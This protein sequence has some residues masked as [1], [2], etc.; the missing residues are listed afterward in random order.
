RAHRRLPERRPPPRLHVGPSRPG[1]RT[2]CVRRE[3]RASMGGARTFRVNLAS[4]L[5][6]HPFAD[7]E[8]LLC[9]IAGCVTAGEARRDARAVAD[10]LRTHDLA[11]GQA[12]AVQLPSDPSAVVA[13]FGTWLA[14]GV[15]VPLHARQTDAEVDAAMDATGPAI[16]VGPQG[17]RSLPGAPV[18]YDPDTAFVT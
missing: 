18:V 16:Y 13:M 17:M 6:D 5:V 4:L 10:R 2:A 11:E 1:R 7:D 14:G 9:T 3:A 8:P 15:F 12:V